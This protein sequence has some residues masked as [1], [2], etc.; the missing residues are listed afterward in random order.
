MRHKPDHNTSKI[1]KWI[2]RNPRMNRRRL[3]EFLETEGHAEYGITHAMRGHE[4]AALRKNIV[5]KLNIK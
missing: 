1:K 2:S 4:F 3:R 5:N